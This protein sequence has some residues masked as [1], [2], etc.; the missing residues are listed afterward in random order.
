MPSSKKFE[1][2]VGTA[3]CVLCAKGKVKVC[4]TRRKSDGVVTE[5]SGGKLK[6]SCQSC[7]R[8][9]QFKVKWDV[10]KNNPTLVVLIKPKCCD[11]R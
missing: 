10:G 4:V 5:P 7:K 6:T 3:N 9:N 1:V 11:L 8:E 2:F